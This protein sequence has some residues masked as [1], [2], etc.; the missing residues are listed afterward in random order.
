MP[1]EY[2]EHEADIGIK[3]T[4]KTV[5]EA[6]AEGARA[7]FGIMVDL[8]KV[9]PVKRIEVECEAENIGSLFVE[10]LNALL[11]QVNI[12]EMF[13]SKFEVKI[14]GTH[15]TA[16]A[17]GEQIDQEKHQTKIEVKAATFSGL[18]YEEKDGV[19]SIQCVVDV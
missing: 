11:A 14:D 10:F 12:A 3:G 5:E 9:D 16:T 7:M 8:E 13:F 1:F 2:I 6:F 17:W 19:H 4:G 18:K 15:L